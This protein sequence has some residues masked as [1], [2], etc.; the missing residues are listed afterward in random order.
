LRSLH[1]KSQPLRSVSIQ[2]EKQT[3][4]LCEMEHLFGSM[5][6]KPRGNAVRVGQGVRRRSR[7]RRRMNFEPR[8]NLY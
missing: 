7:G 1:E 8:R 5:W 4:N 6:N 2:S 3:G